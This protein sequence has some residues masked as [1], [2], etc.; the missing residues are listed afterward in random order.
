[1]SSSG[2]LK[3]SCSHSHLNTNVYVNIDDKHV[4]LFFLTALSSAKQCQYHT[5]LKVQDALFVTG[6][7]WPLGMQGLLLEVEPKIWFT[8]ARKGV[9]GEE[10][11][12]V[13]KEEEDDDVGR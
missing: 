11:V 12:D 6:L 3:A 4:L 10:D 8:R 13:A 9:I 1:M 2:F 5:E 7:N